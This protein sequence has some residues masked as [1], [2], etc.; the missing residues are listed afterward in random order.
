MYLYLSVSNHTV[1]SALICEVTGIQHPVY[2]ASKTVLDVEQWY[3]PLEKLAFTLVVASRKLKHYFE[4]HTIIIIT[5]HPLKA[6]LR[7][8]DLSGR[9]SKWSV[10]LG[11]FDIQFQPRT[12][13]KGQI[14]ADFIV[15][16]TGKELSDKPQ[17]IRKK[18]NQ[19]TTETWKLFVDGASNSKGAGIGIVI[20]TPEN[21][22]L[23]QGIRL[24]FRA[25]NNEAEYEALIGGLQKAQT[26]GAKHLQVF[27]D[28]QLVSNPIS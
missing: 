1:S 2:Y 7:K 28:S 3:L 14:L 24:E 25:S 5:S 26:L 17:P 22:I 19:A 27:G 18:K 21:T 15:E 11:Q 23:E 16:F 20:I 9:L 6:V 13:I 12:A 8:A 10:E 4:A